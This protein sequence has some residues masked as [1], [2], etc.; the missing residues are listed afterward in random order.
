MTAPS[1]I[2]RAYRMH[3]YP[4]A[5]LR[6]ASETDRLVELPREPFNPMLCDQ[7]RAFKHFFGRRAA[8]H[9]IAAAAASRA[10]ASRTVS[11]DSALGALAR[12]GGCKADRAGRP[13]IRV[14]AFSPSSQ[15]CSGCAAKTFR[16]GALRIL[17]EP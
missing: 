9:A 6:H 4:T 13:V 14:D 15:R 7:Q 16:S 11:G 2:D 8:T 3:R 12:Q 17:A 1:P 10:R 5:R